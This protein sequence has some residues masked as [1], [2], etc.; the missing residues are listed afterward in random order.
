MP[1]QTGVLGLFALHVQETS[2]TPTVLSF[3]LCVESLLWWGAAATS[4]PSFDSSMSDSKEVEALGAIER[5]AR[6]KMLLGK[7]L[8]LESPEITDKVGEALSSS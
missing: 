4:R 5:M 1:T 6:N 2:T 8:D 7:M 3:F